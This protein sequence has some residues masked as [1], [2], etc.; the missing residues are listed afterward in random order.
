VVARR[1]SHEYECRSN[2][3]PKRSVYQPTPFVRIL[4]RGHGRFGLGMPSVRDLGFRWF[5]LGGNR[6]IHL[7][8]T[9][10]LAETTDQT[11][12]FLMSLPI[13][14]LDY[15]IGKISVVLT[16]Y[17]I[18]WSAMFAFLT[19]A[20]F[21]MGKQGNVVV[22]PAIFF[23]LLS[24]FTLQL[25]TAVISESVGW[26]ICVMVG[27]NVALNVLLMKLFQNPEV[28]AVTK[29]DVLTWPNFVVQI[30]VV[31]LLIVIASLATAFYFQTRKR[32]L[33]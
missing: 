9:L 6:R 22:L 21:V 26:T 3:V 17:L 27:C 15:S 5:P 4:R 11:R 10:L 7:I 30:V 13:S 28:S 8:G 23:F 32:D 18:P 20:T 1:V 12:L 14:L 16:T 25:V 33:V 24:A 2:T 19:I 31:E 29:S